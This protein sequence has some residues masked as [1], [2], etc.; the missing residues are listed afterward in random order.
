M[1]IISQQNLRKI[2]PFIV[3]IFCFSCTSKKENIQVIQVTD[4]IPA[5]NLKAMKSSVYTTSHKS[6]L[7]LTLTDSLKFDGFKQPLETDAA[8]IVDPT[9]EFQTFLGI[10][11]ALTD[12]AAET[13]AI[14][15]KIRSEYPIFY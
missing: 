4:S 9:K 3:L 13:L 2:L 14:I 7:K 1:Q 10:G 5:L 8:I 6:N 12:A 15:K 11:A